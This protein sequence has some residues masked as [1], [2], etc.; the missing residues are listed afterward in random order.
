MSAL[1][2]R[3]I[4]DVA[5]LVRGR[6]DDSDKGRVILAEDVRLLETALGEGGGRASSVGKCGSG[7]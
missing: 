1:G 3:S 2:L 5:V 4:T 6:V 7:G